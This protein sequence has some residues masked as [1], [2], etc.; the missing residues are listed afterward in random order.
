MIAIGAPSDAANVF[1]YGLRRAD[2]SAWNSHWQ[3]SLIG[4]VG[5]DFFGA[6]LVHNNLQ[7]G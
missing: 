6:Q 7:M 5:A 4:C 1:Y 3:N 2:R